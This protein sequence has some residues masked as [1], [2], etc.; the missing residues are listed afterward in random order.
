MGTIDNQ[1][2]ATVGN[3]MGHGTKTCNPA[4]GKARESTHGEVL[5]KFFCKVLFE[6]TRQLVATQGSC[7]ETSLLAVAM[8]IQFL[9]DSLYY[10]FVGERLGKGLLDFALP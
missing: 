8:S 6:R 1:A 9:R 2:T 10:I 7:Q 5:P 3:V 4:K